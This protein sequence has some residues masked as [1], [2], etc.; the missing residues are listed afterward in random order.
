MKKKF[1]IKMTVYLGTVAYWPQ[2]SYS[3]FSWLGLWLFIGDY[4]DYVC[5]FQTEE[6]AR[7]RIELEGPN[8][9]YTKI[10]NL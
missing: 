8:C 2:Y 6:Q 4:G 3:C 10:I 1:R 7:E 9:N 5:N